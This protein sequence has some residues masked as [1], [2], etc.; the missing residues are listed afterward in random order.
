MEI[1]FQ[2]H[3]RLK[4][5]AKAEEYNKKLSDKLGPNWLER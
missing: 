3:T 5:E 1:L 2:V 4:N